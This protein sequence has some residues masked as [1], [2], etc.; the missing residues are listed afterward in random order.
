MT[1][2]WGTDFHFNFLRDN[3]SIRKF[4]E[5]L[6]KE[7]LKAEGLI[8]TGDIS[9]GHHL[10]DH[11]D[12]FS[13]GFNKPIYFVLG[14]HCYYN[15]SWEAIDYKVQNLVSKVSNLYWLNSGNYATNGHIICGCGGW[16]DAYYGN[17]NSNVLLND[18]YLISELKQTSNYRPFLLEKIRYRAKQE[19][20]LLEKNLENACRTNNE[21]IIVGTHIP[22]YAESA[23][24]EGRP[25]EQDWAPWFSSKSSGDVL[26]RFAE[27]YSD[28]KF[29]IL[30][31]HS[32][33]SGI[34]YRKNNMTIFTGPAVYRNPNICGTINLVEKKLWAYNQFGKKTDFKY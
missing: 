16:Y 2:L 25:S 11:L 19:A 23:W 9:D 14:N 1:I 15:A 28:K 7:N 8:I 10:I 32:H 27:Q 34:Y 3:L 21:V 30:A 5:H 26:D 12:V 17:E 6:I 31:G 20:A 4:G 29:I 24:H 13:E 22:P 18:F 33:G